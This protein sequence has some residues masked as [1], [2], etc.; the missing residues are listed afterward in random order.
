MKDFTE[1][2]KV[3]IRKSTPPSKKSY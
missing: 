1:P 2:A 3:L